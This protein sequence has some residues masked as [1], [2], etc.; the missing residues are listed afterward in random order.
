MFR[1]VA[2]SRAALLLSLGAACAVAPQP[3][4]IHDSPNLLVELAYDPRAGAGH[5]HP[6]TMTAAQLTAILQGIQLHGRDFMGTFGLLSDER[7]SPAFTARDIA[8]LVPHLLT[9]LGKASPK[10]IVTFH[11]TQRDAQQAPLITSGGLFQRNRH[12]Y[13][14]LANART[15]PTA[16]QYETTYEPDSRV[17]PLLPITRF[18]FMTGF[19]PTDWRVPTSE[20]KKIDQWEGYFDESKVVVID[21]SRVATPPAKATEPA[22]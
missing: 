11:L 3:I 9:G 8:A 6:V 21:L 7:S 17:N 22:S 16:L 12:L 4:T 1:S 18:K 15:S 20:A 2:L 19:V 10:D 14:L 13:I 5:T